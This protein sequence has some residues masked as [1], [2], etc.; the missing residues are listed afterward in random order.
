[1]MTPVLDMWLTGGDDDRG[2]V[3]KF[4]QA[5]KYQ[6]AAVVH[7]DPSWDFG[8]MV[9]LCIGARS[10]TKEGALAALNLRLSHLAKELLA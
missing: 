5:F 4:T 3:I 6:A 8:P 9:V 10:Q 7:G 1:M 2:V